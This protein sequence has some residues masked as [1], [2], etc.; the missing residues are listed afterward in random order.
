M[1]L[2]LEE[3]SVAEVWPW[4]AGI[5]QARGSGEAGMQEQ[6]KQWAWGS[7]LLGASAGLQ[8]ELVPA[9]KGKPKAP[10]TLSPCEFSWERC[11]LLHTGLRV[12]PGAATTTTAFEQGCSQ[13][14][15]AGGI[16]CVVSSHQT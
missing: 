11:P 8:A 12:L 15:T 10:M 2:L 6:L 16:F 3:S 5:Q 1:L 7:P 4:R 13:L 14:V 9:C